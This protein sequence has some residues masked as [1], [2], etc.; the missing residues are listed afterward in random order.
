VP[1]SEKLSWL[2]LGHGTEG[3][4]RAD[5]GVVQTAAGALLGRGESIKLQNRIAH[6][7][8][9]DELALRGA[10]GLE[11]TVLTLG[12]RLSSRAYL[13]GSSPPRTL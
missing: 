7:A 12:K 3:A 10:G 9:L 13:T 2:V 8:G 4:N 1:D 11:S 6:A 5:L